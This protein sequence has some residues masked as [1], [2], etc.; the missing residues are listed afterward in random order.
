VK[1]VTL[2]IA[3]IASVGT[4]EKADNPKSLGASPER[5]VEIPAQFH[6]EFHLSLKDCGDKTD[7]WYMNISSSRI[8]YSRS[9][10]IVLSSIQESNS[11]IVLLLDSKQDKYSWLSLDKLSLV[12]EGGRLETVNGEDKYTKQLQTERLRCPDSKEQNAPNN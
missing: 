3:A 9:V 11:E 12:Q 7:P 8:E 10:S 6:G 1:A 5:K 2:A 4:A